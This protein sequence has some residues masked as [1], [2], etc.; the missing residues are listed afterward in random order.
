MGAK[1]MN[2]FIHFR[3]FGN[4]RRIFL[5]PFKLNHPVTPMLLRIVRMEFA[6]E[7]LAAF[8]QVFEASRPR[9]AA[10]PGC[11]LVSLLEDDTHPNVRYTLSIWDGP[12]ALEAY[13]IS[14]LFQATW[15]QT[16]PLFG[17]RP[18]AFS[19]RVPPLGV[20][21]TDA[22]TAAGLFRQWFGMDGG[23]VG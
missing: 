6:P 21:S 10:F 14:E 1:A 19:L 11:R 15:A 17:G 9:I 2:K 8:H 16:K 23:L 7:H 13:R 20:G 12:D 4:A 22:E 5:P 3:G 18:A